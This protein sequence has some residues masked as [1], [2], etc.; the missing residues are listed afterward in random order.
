MFS[1]IKVFFITFIFAGC[2]SLPQMFT[3]LE[4]IADDT[5]IKCEISKEAIQKDKEININ[6]TIKNENEK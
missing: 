4:N 2:Q 6:V 5:A 1:N 3:S